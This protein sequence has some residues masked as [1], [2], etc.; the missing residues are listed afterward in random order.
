MNKVFIIA[1]KRTP[2][3]C[4]L[5]QFKNIQAPNLAAQVIKSILVEQPLIND[6]IKIDECYIGCVLSA[7]VGQA[8]ARQALLEAGLPNDIPCTTVN[9]VCGSGMK[10]LALAFDEITT[11]NS[12]A[13]LAG[14][15][16]SMSNAPYLLNGDKARQGLR[17]GHQKLID[18]MFYDGLEN[19]KDGQL[20]G[21]FAEA[22]AK[23]YNITREQQD[24][25][26]INSLE[27]ALAATESNKFKSEIVA[28]NDIV[29]DEQ[30]YKSDIAKIP[31][32]KPAFA[33]K[34]TV[35]AA[36]SSSISD[37]AAMCLLLD[38]KYI[39]LFNQSVCAGIVAHSSFAKQPEEFTTAVPGAIKK[40]LTKANWSLDE[41]DLFEIN[42][43]FSV[44]VI[45]AIETL[46]LDPNKVNVNG[47]ACAMGHPIG[48][49]GCRIVVSLVHAM[50]DRGC[51]KG[52]ASVCIGGGESMAIAVEV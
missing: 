8:P 37:G 2:I 46:G 28:I 51:H 16:E 45:S 43:A 10:S 34:G 21:V 35:T 48:A 40:V 38:A 13:V 49:S 1:A 52:I 39:N 11:G 42:E 50:L 44:V 24:N 5:G 32:L 3:G 18:H 6:K 4:Y 17:M 25:F 23:K 47:G 7:G 9:K 26:T 20:M 41:V 14:G 12:I 30:I 29:K 22:T 19:Y 33:K 36:N 31:N 27:R 15:M